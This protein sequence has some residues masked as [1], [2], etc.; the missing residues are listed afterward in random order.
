MKITVIANH[1]GVTGITLNAGVFLDDETDTLYLSNPLDKA[2][3]VSFFK[4]EPIDLS[5]EGSSVE[6]LELAPHTLV[7]LSVE[8]GEIFI[9]KLAEG[10]VKPI[11]LVPPVELSVVNLWN[12]ATDIKY[13]NDKVLVKK[14]G[15]KQMKALYASELTRIQENLF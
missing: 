12:F 3:P 8:D 15:Y 7:S 14:F 5:F 1:P 4:P 11:S 13:F 2:V 10:S 9:Q 6:S